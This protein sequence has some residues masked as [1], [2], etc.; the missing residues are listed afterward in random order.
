MGEFEHFLGGTVRVLKVN[1]FVLTVMW[2]PEETRNHRWR[3]SR[4]ENGS[5][6]FRYE[7]S[8]GRSEEVG[9]Q[10]RGHW[11]IMELIWKKEPR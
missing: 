5:G 2:R 6:T 10:K 7:V 1:V 8:F 3:L 11:P 9:C 4:Q